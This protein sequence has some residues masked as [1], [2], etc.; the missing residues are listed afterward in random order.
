MLFNIICRNKASTW[1]A[2]ALIVR[3][4]LGAFLR[5]SKPLRSVYV[6]AAEVSAAETPGAC[7]DPAKDERELVIRSR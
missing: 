4:E 7:R 3:G 2:T 5:A 6:D 1:L